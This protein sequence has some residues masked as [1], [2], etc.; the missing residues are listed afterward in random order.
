MTYSLLAH[1]YSRIKGSQ[2]D[3]ATLSLQHI[4]SQSSVLNQEFT[5]LLGQM[6]HKDIRDT[7][8]YVCQSVGENQERPDIAGVD[9]AGNEQLLCEAKFYAGLTDNQPSGYLKRLQKNDAIGL[10]FICPVVRR[11]AL[12]SR[13][14]DLCKEQNPKAI[15]TFCVDVDGVRMSVLTWAEIID[16]LRRVASAS[17]PEAL[18]DIYQ[19]DGFCQ[20]MDNEAFIPFTAEDFGPEHAIKEDRYYQVP[21]A[22][23]DLLKADK[24]L[25]ATS[26]GLRA[27]AYRN[28]Y[29]RYIRLTDYGLSINFD[30]QAWR[31]ANSV[32][33]PFWLQITDLSWKQP[34][35]IR[36][37]LARYPE[38]QKS[39]I[40]GILAL[41]LYAPTNA[42]LDEIAEDLRRQILDYV[43]D[44]RN[45]NIQ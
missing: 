21:D 30:R 11:T 38:T 39:E 31:A 16:T 34:L 12:W 37:W 7:L 36:K 19:L 27:S 6:L 33:T 5:R 2:E 13:L 8:N 22:V 20:M 28:G 43:S 32:E 42:T 18:P 1:L 4:V 17:V 44:L 14:L 23:F 41:A 3:V 29:V 25:H 40:N 10:A 45:A 26:N 9:V 24:T 15:D 35:I